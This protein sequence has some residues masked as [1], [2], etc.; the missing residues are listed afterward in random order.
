MG[1]WGDG[2]MRRWGN[3]WPAGATPQYANTPMPRCSCSRSLHITAATNRAPRPRCCAP[4]GDEP[5]RDSDDT[6]RVCPWH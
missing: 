3:G 2:A 5:P 6:A 1:R 4:S